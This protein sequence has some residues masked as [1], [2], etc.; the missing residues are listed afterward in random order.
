MEIHLLSNT[1]GNAFTNG[2]FSMVMLDY[3]RIKKEHEG[4]FMVFLGG[5]DKY[6]VVS[7]LWNFLAGWEGFLHY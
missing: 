2:G 6:F 5:L 3:R 7:V 1:V 4:K